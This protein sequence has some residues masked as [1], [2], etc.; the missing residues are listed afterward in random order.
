MN[1][2]G[3]GDFDTVT[4]WNTQHHARSSTASITRPGKRSLTVTFLYDRTPEPKRGIRPDLLAEAQHT[5]SRLH[6]ED[7]MQAMNLSGYRP[8]LLKGRLCSNHH[9]VQIS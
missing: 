4:V 5:L 8:D 1:L 6:A 7:T 9:K 2:N 3:M